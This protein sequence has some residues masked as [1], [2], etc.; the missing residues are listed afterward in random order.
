MDLMSTGDSLPFPYLPP[1]FLPGSKSTLLWLGKV[2]R[3]HH[4]PARM[5]PCGTVYCTGGGRGHRAED[6][7]DC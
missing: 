2:P 6:A 7:L 4:T 3:Q 5:R 1:S